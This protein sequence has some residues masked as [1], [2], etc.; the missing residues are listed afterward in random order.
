MDSAQQGVRLGKRMAG[1]DEEPATA[2]PAP[3]IPVKTDP[4]PPNKRD[5]NRETAA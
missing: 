1:L 5:T 2:P 4:E 3:R